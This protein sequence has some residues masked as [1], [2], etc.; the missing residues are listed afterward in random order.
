MKSNY[1]RLN[2]ND[3][4]KGLIVAVGSAALTVVQTS[5]QAGSLSI[6]WK[7]V[8]TVSLTAA[9]AYLGKNLFENQDGKLG[10]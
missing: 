8:L 2:V 9:V 4:V 6:D 1:F 3:F 10:K 7:L 5:L